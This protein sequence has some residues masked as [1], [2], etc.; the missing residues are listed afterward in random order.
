MD[1]RETTNHG[2]AFGRLPTYA[3]SHGGGP[4]PWIKDSF[5]GDWSPLEAALQAIPVEIG[6]TPRAI[7]CVTAHWIGTEFTVQTHPHPPM[8]YDYGGFPAFTYRVTYPA[9]GSPEVAGR[10]ADLIAGAGLTVR[11]DPD[12]GF[13]HGT[14]VPLVVAFP[15]ATVPVVQLSIRSD[16]DPAVHRTVDG[17]RRVADGHRRGPRRGRACPTARTVGERAA[18]PRLPSPA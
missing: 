4:W 5:G 2:V 9:P 6:S 8:L 7:L 16:F 10:V 17:V 1:A 14:F 3:I 13:D 11:L 12:R 18:G 15:D